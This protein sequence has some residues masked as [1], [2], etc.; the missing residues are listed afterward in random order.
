MADLV[1]FSDR[2][3][4]DPAQPLPDLDS[5]SGKAYACTEG[6]GT[7]FFALVCDP[8]VPLRIE[9]INGLKGFPKHNL[10]RV[11]DHGVVN[12]T[13]SGR[14]MPVLILDRPRGAR[15]FPDPAQAIEPFTD[16]QLARGFL[17]PLV[18]TMR[19]MSQRGVTH[20]NI[21]PDN[22]FYSDPARRSVMVGEC[23]SGPPGLYQP[24]SCESLECV[25][26]DRTAR[27]EG[28]VLDDL[29]SVG[30]TLLSLLT[31]RMMPE[32]TDPQRM[33]FDRINFGSYACLV[34]NTRL[35]MNMV[36]VLRG[37]LTD[38]PRERWTIRDLEL[39]LGGR[40][41]TPK[42]VKLPTKA[43]RP[44]TVGGGTYENVRAVAHAIGRNWNTAAELIR[45]QDFD[46]WLRRSLGDEAVVE[47]VNKVTGGATGIQSAPKEED[48]RL[49]TRV[50]I[51]LDPSAPIRHKG[52]SCHIDG[53]GPTLALN[54]NDDA[55]RQMIAG[56]IGSR[57]VGPWM[58]VQTRSKQDLLELFSK[59]DKL[60]TFLN[61]TG[62]GYGIERVLYE[63]N[64]DIHC[65]SSMI[66]HL[67]V[68]DPE[69]VIP[70]LEAVAQGQ[71][72][73]PIP[74]DRHL[75]AFLGARSSDIDDRLLRPLGNA[76]DKRPAIDALNVMRLLARIQALSR[77]GPMPGLCKWFTELMKPAVNGFH[78]LKARAAVETSMMKASESGQLGEILKIFD[79]Q[80]AQQRDQQG[81]A[82][83][84]QE[85]AHC[86][87]QIAQMNLDLQNKDSLAAEL[88]EQAAAV[89]SGVV[90]SVG[91]T[92]IVILYLV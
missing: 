47:T 70:S 86:A 13:I 1:K 45:G 23:V 41:L 82:R 31:G 57:S 7:E 90:G 10:M 28:G 79:D 49:V 22:L 61:S 58:S 83:A 17:T 44:L 8:K 25:M 59:F 43:G 30:V 91:T 72:R 24:D 67:Y 69:E 84:Q 76:T 12:W 14:R 81:F 15:L 29:F 6:N 40:R 88:G 80:R 78:N 48:A 20:R 34:G 66:E 27:G 73:P 87:V 68:T 53:V 4:I 9:T 3:E 46:N 19:E 56:F 38:E 21:R 5:P 2:F 37:L 89:I 50:A 11:T 52:F 32:P 63:L 74:M 39:W 42:Q 33:I 36:E 35:Q 60:P 71:N 16:E 54:F 26:A 65:M 62:P 75:A 64:E 51:G 18:A 92:A 77:N 85:F 55:T